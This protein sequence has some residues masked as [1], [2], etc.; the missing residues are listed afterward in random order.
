MGIH[1]Y[2][3]MIRHHKCSYYTNVEEID[4]SPEV[5]TYTDN[6]VKTI[7]QIKHRHDPVVMTVGKYPLNPMIQRRLT[8]LF[9]STRYLRIQ[10]ALEIQYDR[11]RGAA[12]S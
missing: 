1:V 6:F 12:V 9:D 8:R 4:C 3:S 2:S 5:L 7:E 11:H 10:G